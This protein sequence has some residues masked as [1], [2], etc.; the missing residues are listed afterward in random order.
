MRQG[1]TTLTGGEAGTPSA[2]AA[3][4]RYFATIEKQGIS[5]NFGTLVS[6]AQ[7]RTAVLYASMNERDVRTIMFWPWI[8]VG[9]DAAAGSIE[10]ARGLAHPR[11]C[12]T[13]SRI[14]ARYVRETGVLTLENALR[15]GEPR[16]RCHRVAHRS[17]PRRHASRP[18]RD[19]QARPA[20]FM[21]RARS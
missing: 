14:I 11:D 2:P 3:L 1:V 15:P 8:S 18:R 9:S 17:G 13:F 4:D 21:M 5:V 12:G 10:T 20:D 19:D 7:A 6:A 16:S